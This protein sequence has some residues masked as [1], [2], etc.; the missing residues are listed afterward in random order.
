MPQCTAPVMWLSNA[1]M[2]YLIACVVYMCLTRS[3]GTPFRDSLTP[4]QLKIKAGAV[5]SRKRAFCAGIIVGVVVLC[6]VRPF[7]MR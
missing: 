7:E 1:A 4:E 2:V 6:I 5:E 3:Y